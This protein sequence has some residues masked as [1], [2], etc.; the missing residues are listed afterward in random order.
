MTREQVRQFLNDP[1]VKAFA[2]G[3]P[4]QVLRHGVW[5][6]RAGDA[7]VTLNYGLFQYRVRPE[8]WIESEQNSNSKEQTDAEADEAEAAGQRE[9]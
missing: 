7:D 9:G 5:V 1:A 6:D 4:T 2:E 3:K 8:G